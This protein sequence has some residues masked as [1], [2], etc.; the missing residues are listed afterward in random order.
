MLT[1]EQAKTILHKH[2]QDPHL[3]K[4][5]IAVSSAMAAMALYYGS[6]PE[7]WAAIGYLHDV[8]YEKYPTEHLQHTRELLEPEGIDEADIRCILAHGYG[9]C[10]D[11]QPLSV[12]EKCL[13]TVD[14]LTGIV[15]AAALMR[16]TGITDLTVQSAKKKFKD[17]K[18]AA[19]CNRDII[20]NGCALLGLD[21]DVV[22]SRTI[23]GMQTKAEELGLLGA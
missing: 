9:S 7:Y 8:D 5:A 23:A 21:L 15:M 18:F 12:I 14:E 2:T 13:Y 1:L 3:K 6:E 20:L 16:P 4:H 17:K 10:S 22:L 11:V 19:K